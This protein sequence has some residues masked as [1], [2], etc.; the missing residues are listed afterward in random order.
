[1]LAATAAALGRA[2]ATQSELANPVGEYETATVVGAELARLHG[3]LDLFWTVPFHELFMRATRP[4][5][6]LGLTAVEDAVYRRTV[7]T[8][9]V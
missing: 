4:P 3:L 7:P 6:T 9:A 2:I 1:M 5:T 8:G